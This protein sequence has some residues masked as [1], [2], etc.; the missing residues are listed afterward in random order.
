MSILHQNRVLKLNASWKPIG[1]TTPAEAFV[2]MSREGS[3]KKNRYSSLHIEYPISEDGSV[4][5]EKPC[6]I[7][8]VKWEDWIALPVRYFDKA[9]RTSSLQIRVPTIIIANNYNKVPIKYP[10]Y[11]KN[12]V[13]TRDKGTCAITETKLSKGDGNI[14]HWLPASRG[15][16]TNFENCLLLRKDLNSRKGDMTMEEFCKKFGY[17]VPRKP[18]RPTISK[19]KINNSYDIKDWDIFLTYD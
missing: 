13:W 16:A 19:V 6:T 1:L 4:D 5:F 2:A 14:D 3:D 8:P 9:V 15:G 11:S 17:K 10:R 7:I 18:Q 12:A